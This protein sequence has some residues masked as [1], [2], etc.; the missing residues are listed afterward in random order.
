MSTW[1]PRRFVEDGK[2]LG[3]WSHESTAALQTTRARKD[4]HSPEAMKFRASGI[5]N[6]SISFYRN[7]SEEMSLDHGNP[8]ECTRKKRS[9]YRNRTLLS[10]VASQELPLRLMTKSVGNDETKYSV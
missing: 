7:N 2:R 5:P 10:P 6:N 4:A 8:R 9:K 3:L 1:V